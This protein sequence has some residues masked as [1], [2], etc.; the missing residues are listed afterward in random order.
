MAPNETFADFTD[1]VGAYA[2]RFFMALLAGLILGFEG[3]YT[4]RAAGLRTNTLLVL[5]TCLLTILSQAASERL[6]GDP[7][8]IAAQVITGIGFLGAGVIF[9]QEQQLQG[10]TTAAL[11]FT[12]AAIG[13]TI[14]FG[15]I[16]SGLAIA[17]VVV[18]ILQ[19][20]M[21]LGRK[22]RPKS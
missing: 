16:W 20:L 1:L 18:L 8:R 6:G 3:E 10:I 12:A 5:A 14:G 15:F 22:I 9:R 21:P 2:P 19:G 17:L 4:R 11:I 13:M 7:M